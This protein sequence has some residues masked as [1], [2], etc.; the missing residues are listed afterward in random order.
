MGKEISF[1][2]GV[3][4]DPRIPACHLLRRPFPRGLSLLIYVTCTH[5]PVKCAFPF[6]QGIK[7]CGGFCLWLFPHP[8]GLLFL[9]RAPW[10]DLV[11]CIFGNG[12]LLAPQP[13]ERGWEEGVVPIRPSAGPTYP[14]DARERGRSAEPLGEGSGREGAW[15]GRGRTSFSVAAARWV[16]LTAA[17]TMAATVRV[18]VGLRLGWTG[19][20]RGKR[21]S[22]GVARRPPLAAWRRFPGAWV[23]QRGADEEGGPA[24]RGAEP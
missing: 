8:L 6:H 13:R 7:I 20:P 23:L 17:L 15:M 14:Q 12:R 1:Q 4:C 16:Q 5:K 2:T 18:Q 3:D 11:K 21:A 24:G 10:R 19:E 9:T 22:E